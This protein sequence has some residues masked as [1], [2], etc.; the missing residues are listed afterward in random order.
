MK[1]NRKLETAVLDAL[2]ARNRY[3]EIARSNI[4]RHLG[5]CECETADAIYD[6]AY[7]LAVDAIHDAGAPFEMACVIAR[8]VAQCYAQP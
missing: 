4:E 2:A 1:P 8:E 3:R 7:T 6:N 5:D